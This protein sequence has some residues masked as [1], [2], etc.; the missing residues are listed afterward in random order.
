MEKTSLDRFISVRGAR[1][2]NLKN[3]SIDIPKN[4]FVVITGVSGSGKSSLAFD[5]IYAEGHRRYVESLSTYA[6]QFLD[7]L[8]KPDIDSIDGLSPS[9]SIEQRNTNRNP[10]STVGTVT[11]INDY[12]RLLFAKI[13]KPYSPATGQELRPQSSEEIVS[14][15]LTYPTDT[16]ILL[17]APIVI[18]R[19]GEHR[20]EL[21]KAQKAGF[22][23]AR[24]DGKLYGLSDEINLDKQKKHNIS[25]LIDKI[26]VKADV[27]PRVSQA[28]ETALKMANGLV[29]I[30]IFGEPKEIPF[31]TKYSC[32]VSGISFPDPEPRLF[33]FNSPVGACPA[34]NGLGYKTVFDPDMIVPDRNVSISQGALG[35]WTGEGTARSARNFEII[36]NL[37]KHF[38]FSLDEPLYKLSEEVRKVIFH[39]TGKEEIQFK[40]KKEQGNYR[41][42][43]TFP[44]IVGDMEKRLESASD[45][46]IEYL[47]RFQSKQACETCRG[48]R[49][50][51]EA[52]AFRINSKNIADVNSLGIS[53]LIHFFHKLELTG[54]EAL[55]ANE[56]LKE[57]R[58]R[59]KFLEEVGLGYLSLGRPSSTL[60][61]GEIQRVHLATQIGGSLVGVLYVLDEPS[62]GLHQR[63]ND[64]L[65]ASLRELQGRGN[66][67][68]VVEHDRDTIEAADFVIDVGPGAGRLGGE[69]VA[70]GTPQAL[71]KNGASLTSKFLKSPH[72]IPLPEKRRK[73]DP[74]RWLTLE[75]CSENNLRNV[76]AKVPLGLFV[77]VTGVSGSGKSSLILHTLVPAIR[78]VVGRSSLKQKNFTKI[79]GIEFVDKVINVDQSPIGRSPRSN[80]STYS[81]LFS[82]IRLLFAQTKDAQVRGFN[83]G[84]FSF[85]VKSGRCQTCEGAGSIKIAMHFL[86]DVYVPCHICQGARYSRETLQV[87]YRGKNIAQ[88][89]AMSIEEARDFFK[90]VPQ[91]AKYLDILNDVGLGYITLGQSATTL[92]G[93]EAQRMKLA[94]ELAKRPTGKTVYVLDEP[95]TGLHFQDISNLLGVI[96]RLTDQGNTLII[97]EHN[98]DIIKHADWIIDMGPEGGSGGGEM[99]GAGT[100]EEIVKAGRGHTARYL[101][102]Y[103]R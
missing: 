88:V 8:S 11:E 35:L 32:P 38:K 31:S 28:V 55:L 39:G 86:P 47:T 22:S 72:S 77:C 56:I 2:H 89:L 75:G 85:N 100:P 61:G 76:S 102:N 16:R 30:Q 70:S 67:I 64:K 93:G 37:S 36:E 54:P 6:R 78:A 69:I 43:Q 34:C 12:L 9:I 1:E 29:S 74:E 98:L 58:S 49:L 73:P 87:R 92:S 23:S 19:K 90:N 5:T 42:L 71:A 13:A 41:A 59:L 65:I 96:H 10:R 53:D 84:R 48:T 57:I 94:R 95:S 3:I 46:E 14:R 91:I 4:Q 103:L 66:S 15:V 33:S 45:E 21:E 27:R 20:K 18:D 7:Q 44:G 99:I 26:V 17:F 81:G 52:L 24:I 50:K 60:S 80:P 62:I 83:Q 82:S 79:E 40:F 97:I 51:P 25:I 68:L 63:D 101:K